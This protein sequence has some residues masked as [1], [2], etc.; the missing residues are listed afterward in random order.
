[1]ARKHAFTLVELLVV[2]A[3]IA[4]LL[5]VLLPAMGNVK[6]MARRIQCANH[7]KEIGHAYSLYQ[8]NFN[9]ALPTPEQ[10]GADGANS[11]IQHY[12]MY[13]RGD[14][15]GMPWYNMGCLFGAGLIDDGKLFYCPATEGWYDE[16][17][18]YCDPTPWG[19]LPQNINNPP[20]GNGNQWIRAYKGYAYWPQSKDI[21]KS[22]VATEVHNNAVGIYQVNYP[23]TPKQANKLLQNKAFAADY[24][25]HLIKGSGWNVDAV[26]PDGHVSFQTQPKSLA[27]GKAMFFEA[28]QYP[29]GVVTKNADGSLT[30][31]NP[32]EGLNSTQVTIAEFM[33]G[34]Q[35]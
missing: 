3:I 14:Q 1:M 27:N 19:T 30:W 16:Y 13:R 12:F 18:G 11:W 23:K 9:G 7:L 31:N 8:S 24:T 35:P 33:F 20:K 28:G 17:K 10:S 25:F 21:V 32:G 34:L 26:F 15:T 2:I 5:S 22:N 29:A 4:V 6:N